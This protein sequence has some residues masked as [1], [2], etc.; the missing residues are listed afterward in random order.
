MKKASA[1]L[2]NNLYTVPA[3]PA[4]QRQGVQQA[5]ATGVAVSYIEARAQRQ[6]SIWLAG[7]AGR[8]ALVKDVG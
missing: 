6:R 3:Q 5:S 7:E 4:G 1:F 8:P 2:S